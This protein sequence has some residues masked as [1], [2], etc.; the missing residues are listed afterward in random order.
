MNALFNALQRTLFSQW[1]C[2]T[3]MVRTATRENRSR[4]RA[5]RNCWSCLRWHQGMLG[6]NVSHT[7]SSE[8]MLYRL[9]T[10][11]HGMI[12]LIY[13]QRMLIYRCSK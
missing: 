4:Q 2:G 11:C 1:T 8:V 9:V 5:N 10:A 3:T 6:V 7:A 13:Q 12:P